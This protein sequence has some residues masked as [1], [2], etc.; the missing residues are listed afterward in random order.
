MAQILLGVAPVEEK[1]YV[2]VPM[3]CHKCS[4]LKAELATAHSAGGSGNM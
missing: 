2:V 1:S 4:H 3:L